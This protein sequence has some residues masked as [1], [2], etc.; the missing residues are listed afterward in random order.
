MRLRGRVVERPMVGLGNA[1]FGQVGPFPEEDAGQ[2]EITV[3]AVGTNDAETTQ[4]IGTVCV[5]RC[6]GD[7][8]D[9]ADDEW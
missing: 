1:W 7:S 2:V 3:R 4:R 8:S 9:P 6:A 5:T